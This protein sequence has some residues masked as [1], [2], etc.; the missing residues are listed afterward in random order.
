MSEHTLAETPVNTWANTILYRLGRELGYP[1]NEGRG[2]II[3]EPDEILQAALSRIR[4][5]E[6]NLP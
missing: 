5:A 2:S 4:Y 1:V 3:A 6:E